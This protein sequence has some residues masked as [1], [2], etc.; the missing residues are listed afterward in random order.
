MQSK[1]GP[2]WGFGVIV[3]NHRHFVFYLY[4]GVRADA[5]LVI[6]EERRPSLHG[7]QHLARQ[8]VVFRYQDSRRCRNQSDGIASERASFGVQTRHSVVGTEG[9][10]RMSEASLKTVV[11]GHED[12]LPQMHERCG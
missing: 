1:C 7:L 4:R 3:S 10:L 6:R 12:S 8:K 9:R 5:E 11:P 2:A